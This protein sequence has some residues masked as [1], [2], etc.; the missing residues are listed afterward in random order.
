MAK[1]R[2]KPHKPAARARPAGPTWL[3]L[4]AAAEIPEREG[5]L[6]RRVGWGLAALLAIALAAFAARY[7]PV[8]DA[9]T[10]TDF[11]GAYAEGAR[12]IQRGHVDPTRYGVI[13]PVYEFVLALVGLPIRDLFV[14]AH[15]I[16]LVSVVAAW[17]LWYALLERRFDARHALIAGAFLATN[18][19]VFRYGYSVTTDALALALQAATLYLL[20]ARGGA[21]SA[22]WAGVV[23]ALAFLTRYNAI[24][25]LPAGL[26]A[27]LLGGTERG[28][29]RRSAALFAA[30]FLALT[31][32]WVAFSLSHG[33]AFR[34]QLHHNIAYDVFAKARGIPWDEYQEKLQSQ[35]PTLWSVIARDPGA[36]AARELFNVGDHLRQDAQ[37]LLGWPVAACALLGLAVGWRGGGLRR[38]WPIWVAGALLFLTLVPVF[39]SERY[40]LPLVPIVAALAAFPF[41]S[42]RLALALGPRRRLWLKSAVLALPLWF[43]GQAT[44]AQQRFLATQFPI[45]VLSTS[46]ALA[47]LKRPGD[48]LI[49]R[50]PHIAYHGQVEYLAFPFAKGLGELAGFARRSGA[51]WI[52][53]SW[54]EAELRPGYMYLLDTTAHVPGLAVRFAT[55]MHPAV[56]YE[57]QPGFGRD[58]DWFANDTL[59]AVHTAHAR[60]L[61]Q[62]RDTVA[63]YNLAL[64]E[65]ERGQVD[66]AR[67][68]I[69]RA[70]RLNPSEIRYLLLLGDLALRQNDLGT[71][72][73]AFA[74]VQ[75]IDPGNVAA[76][77]GRGWTRLAAQ[78]PADAAAL[79]RPVIAH[80]RDPGTLSQ[81]VELY[82][83]VGDPQAEAQARETLAR[84]EGGR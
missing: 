19:T 66:E 58:P 14:A 17:L 40:S 60:L 44:V 31:V 48:R 67:S 69:E 13:G 24:Y 65:R 5:R 7:H 47:P 78:R 41:A 11:Y 2:T 50:K 59:M 77:I 64:V 56:L 71:A 1:H 61:I 37:R 46:R 36:V 3:S 51:R 80:T 52:Y 38:G 53:Y 74:R 81:M 62:P 6:W 21:A 29:A 32:P 55:R 12:A 18:G 83:L 73:Q 54:L 34:F 39:Y 45:E 82:H 10:E 42:P 63:L 79:W 23:G 15:L 75:L 35:F 68:L 25:L 57:I 20:L 30:G 76:V 43:A 27:L 70:A 4:H 84:L 72:E 8:G 49:A 16:S 33:G 26:I 22:W 9:F 28:R